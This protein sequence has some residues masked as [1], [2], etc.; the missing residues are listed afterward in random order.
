MNDQDPDEAECIITTK[1]G[2]KV[3]CTASRRRGDDIMLVTSIDGSTHSYG[4]SR[5]DED[6]SLHGE[7][8]AEARAVASGVEAGRIRLT[9]KG[10]KAVELP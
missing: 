8:R 9:E 10:W 6:G 7:A 5:M 3:T 2:H 4:D 1:N